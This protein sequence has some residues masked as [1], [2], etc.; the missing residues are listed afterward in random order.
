MNEQYKNLMQEKAREY[1]KFYWQED[2][3]MECKRSFIAGANALYNELRDCLEWVDV[4]ERLPR[5]DCTCLVRL[6]LNGFTHNQH[7]CKVSEF[8]VETQ[9]FDYSNVK[10]WRK[11]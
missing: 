6:S 3:R 8:D 4:E 11:I 1:T 9:M 10:F 7:Q 2:V 5:M